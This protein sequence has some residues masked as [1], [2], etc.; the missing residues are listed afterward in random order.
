MPDLELTGR[1]QRIVEAVASYW[2]E[3]GYAPSIREIADAVDLWSTSAAHRQIR[4][5]VAAGVLAKTDGIP[6]SLRVTQ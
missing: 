2:L 5:L 4:M 6:R 3:H 1:Q